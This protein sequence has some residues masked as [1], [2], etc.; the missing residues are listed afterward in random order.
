MGRRKDDDVRVGWVATNW[1]WDAPLIVAQYHDG[2]IDMTRGEEPRP[3]WAWIARYP[4]AV[5]TT[6]G[7]MSKFDRDRQPDSGTEVGT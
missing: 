2:S 7:V 3:G 5:V 6:D 1:E 4:H